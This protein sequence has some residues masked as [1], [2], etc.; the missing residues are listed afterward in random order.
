MLKDS[1]ADCIV[2]A[3]GSLPL[4]GL[5]N[6]YSGLRQVVWVAERSSRHMDWNE[7]PEGVG[8]KADI[9]VWHEIV[10]EKGDAS[11]SELPA[12]IPDEALSS[13]VIISN[14]PNSHDYSMVTFTQKV[15]TQSL[16]LK[17]VRV[18]T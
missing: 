10:D 11:S 7:V 17:I 18:L 2:A 6:Q 4:E 14:K 8:G 3:A 1:R 9:A 12:S 15:G 16:N 5:F 13:I